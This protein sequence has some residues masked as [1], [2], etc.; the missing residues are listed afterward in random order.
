MA[1][2]VL[3]RAIDVMDR[4]WEWG[5]A[6][7][8]TAACD[9]FRALHGIDPM[10]S[11]RGRYMT[12]REAHRII[13]DMGGFVA[14]AET[15]AASAGLSAGHGEPGEIGVAEHDGG[16]ALVIAVGPGAWAGKTLT[17]MTTVPEALEFWRAP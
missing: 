2:I 16:L 3:A 9:V 12:R 17:G 13:R 6:D 7:C 1:G 15:L 5:K 8:C 11:L 14:M 10:A 4:P